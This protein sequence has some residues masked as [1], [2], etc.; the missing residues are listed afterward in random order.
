MARVASL[1]CR[2]RRGASRSEPP[3]KFEEFD[4]TD[5]RD[6]LDITD[7][8]MEHVPLDVFYGS[9]ASILRSLAVGPVYLRSPTD[10]RIPSLSR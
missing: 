1:P 4:L 8:A 3:M 5:L 7:V 10:A 6:E 2:L 9:L